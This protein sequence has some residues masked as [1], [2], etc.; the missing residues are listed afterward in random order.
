MPIQP[1][2]RATGVV[3]IVMV[4]SLRRF[5][6]DMRPSPLMTTVRRF[7]PGRLRRLLPRRRSPAEHFEQVRG[8][9]AYADFLR[10]LHPVKWFEADDQET[11]VELRGHELSTFRQYLIDTYFFPTY[12][13]TGGKPALLDESLR[14]NPAL[15]A[16]LE[17]WVFKVR[18]T[19]N[20]LVVVKL[21]RA[22]DDTPF[23]ELSKTIL[24]I[25][26]MMPAPGAEAAANIP[27]Q[28]QLAMDVV[29]R[30]VEACGDRF[31]V[32]LPHNGR[33]KTTTIELTHSYPKKKLPLHD[34]HITYLFS[35]ITAGHGEIDV[36]QLREQ[37]AHE[38]VGLLESTMLV[39]N[40]EF[41]Y[42]RYKAQ[43]IE[44]VFEADTASWEDEICLITP[45][46]SFIFCPIAEKTTAFI[47]GSA[48]TDHKQVYADYWKG[49]ARGIEHIIALKN[50]VQLLERD[51]TRL[52]EKIP[53]ITRK[54]A[55]GNLSRSDQQDILDLA[56]GIATLFKSLPQ[57]RDALVPSSV[58][59]ASYATRKFKRLM[60]SL[61]IYEIERHIETNVQELNAFLAHFNSIQLQ[62]N[63][64]RTNL[65]FSLLTVLFSILVV[66]SFLADLVEIQWLDR[67]DVGAWPY[68]FLLRWLPGSAGA[69]AVIA[70][71]RSIWVLGLLWLGLLVAIWLFRT[72]RRY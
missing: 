19:R 58:F 33:H 37:H 54:A 65:V 64:Q 35:K 3:S 10:R 47:S 21:E 52:L 13:F 48:R 2:L 40:D 17:E 44:D 26:R 51:T 11:Q 55:D 45:E 70:S 32:E 29:A 6:R 60:E 4:M 34:R 43:Q 69:D 56:T 67:A 20:G 38:V 59:R 62:Q 27:T 39:E 16:Q 50:E 24:E 41:R 63:E 14:S 30:F 61:G 5:V 15:A 23:I 1:E 53:E 36:R 42:P 46:A 22:L 12:R 49:I 7:L 71:P 25:Q 57:Q 66:P 68:V 9:I 8:S 18:L 28:W 72:D 31:L